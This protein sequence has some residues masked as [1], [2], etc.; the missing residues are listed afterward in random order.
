MTRTLSDRIRF[1]RKQ[2][3]LSLRELALNAGTSK[4]HVWSLEK[5]DSRNP[6]LGVLRGLSDAMDIPIHVLAGESDQLDR[7]SILCRWVRDLPTEDLKLVKATVS[8][9]RGIRKSS[10]L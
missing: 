4:N 9:L 7:L 8:T 5:G 10:D 6:T 1:F 3:G 2:R